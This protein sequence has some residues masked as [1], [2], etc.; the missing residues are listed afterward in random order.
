[1]PTIRLHNGEF[2][3]VDALKFEELNQHP[4]HLSSGGY[5][6]RNFRVGKATKS[7]RMH[8][9]VIGKPPKGFVTDHI[10]T[11]KLDNRRVN[12]RFV[13]KAGNARNHRSEAGVY[14]YKGKWNI[15][16]QILNRTF[17][18]GRCETEKE[19]LS[20]AALLRGAL[21]YWE[22]TKGDSRG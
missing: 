17:Y 12:L 6:I 5:A 19:A 22:L 4:W 7:V 1:M 15:R 13:T 10:N 8:H 14:Y 3:I 11:N 18:F 16:L 9:M 21:M 2:A 20:I